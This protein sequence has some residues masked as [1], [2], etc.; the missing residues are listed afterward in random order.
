LEQAGK[1]TEQDLLIL[2]GTKAL[3]LYADSG[4]FLLFEQ[5]EGDMPQLGQV[6]STM[7]FAHPAVILIPPPCAC[8]PFGRRA[9]QATLWARDFPKVISNTQCRPFSMPQ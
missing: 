7:V 1:D 3:V 2:T 5:I 8:T 9:G 6:P 4:R